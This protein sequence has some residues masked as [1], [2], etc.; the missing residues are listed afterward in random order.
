MR[1]VARRLLP[2]LALL[3]ASFACGALEGRAEPE[4][5]G[6][7]PGTAGASGEPSP[8]IPPSDLRLKLNLHIFGLSYHLDRSGSRTSHLDNELNYGLGLNHQFYEDD[9]GIAV[10]EAGFFKDSGSNWAKFAGAGYQFKL[11]DRWRSGADLLAIHS[12]TYNKGHP[13]IAPVPRLTYDIGKPGAVML[14]VVYIP[15]IPDINLFAVLAFY[16]TIQLGNW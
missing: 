11:G 2:S 10:V 14:N 8:E 12:E 1:Y 4:V 15:K 16:V 13:F 9:R 6:V 7:V 5:P 3:F